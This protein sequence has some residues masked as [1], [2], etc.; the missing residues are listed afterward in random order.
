MKDQPKQFGATSDWKKA[1]PTLS[2]VSIGLELAVQHEAFEA[3]RFRLS[4]QDFRNKSYS[5]VRLLAS[6]EPFSRP[7][8]DNQRA[9]RQANAITGKEERAI[10]FST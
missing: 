4:R 1:Q 7:E 3:G 8:T 9:Y 10:G 5:W 6:P 2:A